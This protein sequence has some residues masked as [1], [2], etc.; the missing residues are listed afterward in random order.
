[1][2]GRS[3]PQAAPAQQAPQPQYNEWNPA[4]P[5]QQQAPVQQ[6]QQPA[7]VQQLTRPRR[8]SRQAR[9]GS[10]AGP[11]GTAAVPAAGAGQHRNRRD[12]PDQQAGYQQPAAPAGTGAAV[13][14]ARPGPAAGA[15]AGRGRDAVQVQA[16]IAQGMDDATISKTT[17]APSP[18]VAAIRA[19][20]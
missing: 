17:G 19:I 10:A 3:S 20:S 16:L 6:Y 11:A 15:T 18:A 14:A 7:P 2:A 13:P 9:L 12:C 4:P 5:V 1:V 8:S